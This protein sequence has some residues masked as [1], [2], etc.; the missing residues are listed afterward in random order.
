MRELELIHVSKKKPLLNCDTLGNLFMAVD[1]FVL[2][3]SY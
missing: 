2:V 1:T 3:A